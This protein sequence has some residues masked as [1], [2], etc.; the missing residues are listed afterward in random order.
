MIELRRE[1]G[2]SL[3]VLVAALYVITAGTKPLVRALRNSNVAAVIVEAFIASL[4]TA[5]TARPASSDKDKFPGET[6][7]T[8]G[9][10]TSVCANEKLNKSRAIN[11]N[12]SL[13]IRFGQIDFRAISDCLV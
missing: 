13:F 7:V 3:A 6:D 8:V 5:D 12:K 11:D 2:L 1:V 9:R 4:K 10:V